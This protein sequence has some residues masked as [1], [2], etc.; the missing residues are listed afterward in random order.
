MAALIVFIR[1]K[2]TTLSCVFSYYMAQIS[3]IASR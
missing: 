2:R 1:K 3:Q